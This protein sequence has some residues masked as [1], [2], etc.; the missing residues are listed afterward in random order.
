MITNYVK[1]IKNNISIYSTKKSSN[2]LDGTYKSIYKGKSLN[3]EDLREYVVGD[4]VKDIDWKASARSGKML[5]R[6]Y[7]AEK[8]HN[9][10]IVFD[11]GN[12]MLADT[13]CGESKKDVAIL[14][15]GTIAYLAEKNGDYVGAIYNKEN[16]IKFFPLKTGE[17]SLENI[18]Y[19]FA[20]DIEKTKESDIEKSLGYIIKN[21][22]K[23]MVILVVTD[24]EGINKIKV[25]TLKK[26]TSTN[27]ILFVNINDANLIEKNTYDVD[28]CLYIPDLLLKDEK[29]RK[30]EIE[31]KQKLQ[32]ECINKLKKFKAAMIS[33][34]TSN[35]IIKKTVELLERHR[36]ANFR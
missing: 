8:K 25:E 21:L 6:Q 18:L 22:K 27:D 3:F 26:I 7:I 10:M 23:R 36:N 19:N 4:N 1:K 24:I 14:I 12:K 9:L 35:D 34:S 13:D 31:T 15:A 30:L 2:I 29:L 5:V 11:T 28:T 17:F 20:K 32:G 16:I 33:I